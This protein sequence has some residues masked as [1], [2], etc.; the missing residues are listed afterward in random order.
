MM[1]QLA[2]QISSL[3]IVGSPR[4]DRRSAVIGRGI[5]RILPHLT[6]F[7]GQIMPIMDVSITP[8]PQFR[9][10]IGGGSLPYYLLNT[11]LEGAAYPGRTLAQRAEP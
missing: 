5:K 6:A 1:P 3:S 2:R 4:Q 11:P 10:P 8:A 9:P 7:T